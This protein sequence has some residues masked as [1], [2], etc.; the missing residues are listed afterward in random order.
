MKHTIRKTLALVVALMSTT[1]IG[2]AAAPGSAS[3]ASAGYYW[4]TADLDGDGDRYDAQV[5]WDGGNWRFERPVYFVNNK[6]YVA[7]SFDNDGDGLHDHA[8][9]SWDGS[10]WNAAYS[11]KTGFYCTRPAGSS[12]YY[13]EVAGLLWDSRSCAFQTTALTTPRH[14]DGMQNLLLELARVTGQAVGG[15]PAW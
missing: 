11:T 10:R 15:S 5:W 2:L 6:G 9:Y 8:M 7:V 4:Y 13:I 3:A 12:G 14:R 1:A